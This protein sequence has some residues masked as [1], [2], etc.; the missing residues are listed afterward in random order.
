MTGCD[1]AAARDQAVR[2]DDSSHFSLTTDEILGK[3]ETAVIVVDHDGSLRYAN[4]FAAQLF[5]FP[6][7]AQLTN[8]PFRHLG[9]HEEDMGK[10]E[11]LEYQA[12]RGRDWEGT[13]AIRRPDKSNYFVRMYAAPMR[14]SAGEVAGTVIMA[15]E[16]VFVGSSSGTGRPGL[17]DRI[18]ERL[19]G[20]LALG[21]T[22]E[23]VADTLVPQFADHCFIDL[24]TKEGLV[25]RVLA[26]A[27]DWT[28]SRGRWAGI[29]E[30][31]NY[32]PNHLVRR[33]IAQSE[34]ILIEDLH[35]EE[36]SAPTAAA[37]EASKEAGMSS[38]IAAPLMMRGEV[39]GVMTLALSN[40]TERRTRHYVA[41]DRDLVA[42]IASRV[43]IAVDN[44]MLFEEERA[45]ALAF[46]NSLLPAK[47]PELDGLEVAYRYVPAKPLETHGQGIQTQV[48][49]DWYDIIP[50][51]AGRV[52]IVIGDVEG[53]G[54]RAAAIMGQLRSALRAFAQDD[55][56]P[57]DILRR[58][59]DW[60]RKM[61]EEGG[62]QNLDPPTASCTYLIYD[63]W[64]RKLTIAN[65]GHMSPLII[66]EG[67]VGQM[68][69]EYENVLLGVGVPTYRE[70]SRA[71]PAGSTLIFYTDGLVDRR[72]RA[73]GPGHYDD[74]EVLDMLRTAIKRVATQNVDKVAQAAE[75][76][77]PGEIDDDMAIL[78]V[79]TA[80]QDLPS[81]N[82]KCPAEPIRVSEA[83]KMAFGTF[84][85]CGMDDEQADLACLLVSEVV[86][87][88]VLHTSAAPAPRNEFV[89]G[90]VGK[91][92]A[93]V[94]E[95]WIDAPLAEDFAAVN[96]NSGALAGQEFRLRIRK[97]KSSVWVEVFDSDLRLP[98]IR[99]AGENDEGGRGLYLVDQL[100]SRWGS[101][102]TEDGK[103]VWFEMPIKPQATGM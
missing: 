4:S 23:R 92:P 29:G 20:S 26:S 35:D 73:D 39:L 64:T 99:L 100:A 77:V 34:T 71:L 12:C 95:D 80:R 88:V 24:R 31:V 66:S 6:D 60:C 76:A 48:G 81:W 50:L 18:G 21:D 85:E 15:K 82:L 47:P 27:W 37:L 9:F 91:R 53:R 97:G 87:N 51:S 32:P 11:N 41:D 79:R 96:G 56:A 68:E 33:A 8:V 36:Q 42:A 17:L 78:V 102:P 1:D 40:L 22:L 19:G 62:D 38:V 61:T 93:G 83:R 90:A 84:V 44:A 30:L 74:A 69:L 25:R 14:G 75:N 86:T 70:E 101:R 5:G 3:V 67:D 52:G 57:G 13:L 45:T 49:G 55:K 65:A 63:P 98:R 103:A 43:S 46:Q 10:V 58:L 16:A 54:A 28:P 7:A 2:A 89:F 72:H 59:D 94:L